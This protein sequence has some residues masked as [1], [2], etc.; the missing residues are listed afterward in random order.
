GTPELSVQVS[1]VSGGYDATSDELRFS[2]NYRATRQGEVCL[3]AIP[4]AE[5]P[6]VV[7]QEPARSAYVAGITLDF[8]FGVEHE[9]GVEGFFLEIRDLVADL[10]IETESLRTAATTETPAISGEIE[11][12]AVTL[13]A[14]VRVVFD[15]AIV[16]D[17]RISL[18]ELKSITSEN[19]EDL[20]QILP[21]G[22]LFAEFP[23][24]TNQEVYSEER[25]DPILIIDIR[26]EDIFGGG[27]PEVFVRTD[28]TTLKDP[29]L[30]LIKGLSETGEKAAGLEVLNAPLAVLDTSVAEL[31]STQLDMENALDF[32]TPALEYFTLLEVFN[33]DISQNSGDVGSLLGIPDFDI[34]D[35]THRLKLQNL[36]E[37]EYNL[38]LNPD[39]DLSL[40]LPEL[41]SLFNPDFE[42]PEYL[43]KFQ[44][45]LG[46]PYVPT[47]D[48]VRSDMKSY[49][50]AFPSL[51]GLLDYIRIT[52]RK[53]LFNG[54]S[55]QLASEPFLFEGAGE[56]SAAVQVNEAVDGLGLNGEELPD[57]PFGA[58]G[59]RFDFDTRAD[60][61]FHG[62][63]PPGEVDS[64]T[65]QTAPILKPDIHEIVFV[66]PRV[67]DYQTLIHPLT[68]Q[69]DLPSIET[70]ILDPEIDGVAQ[71]SEVLASFTDIDALHIIAHGSPGSLELGT[72]RLDST[73]LNQY[74]AR[75]EIWGDSLITDGDILLYGC[76]IAKGEKG[77]E[78]VERLS[79]LTGADVAA[80]INSTGGTALGGDWELEYSTGAI[81]VQALFTAPDLSSYSS[82]LNGSKTFEEVATHL[83]DKTFN[84]ATIVTHGFQL[85]NDGGNSLYPLADAIRTRIDSANDDNSV[86][87]L[88]YDVLEDGQTGVFNEDNSTL[89][90][91]TSN[92]GDLVLLFDWA[93]ESNEYS[94]GWGSAAGEALFTMVAGLGIVDPALGEAN[95]T[96][97]HFVAHSFGTAVTS[98]AIERLARF[99]VPVDQVTYLDPH[100]FDQGVIP[101][102]EA[103]EMFKLGL[104]AGYG[105][106]VW[107]NVAFADV[108]YQTEFPP[109]GR[110]IPGAFNT[111]VNDEVSGLSA[112]SEVWSE[113][114]LDTVTDTESTTGYAFSSIA[115]AQAGSSAVAR[116]DGNF[117]GPEQ[118]HEHSDID[119]DKI[120]PTEARL[121]TAAMSDQL[122]QNDID[123]G[124]W[125]PIWQPTTIANGTLKYGGDEHDGIPGGS[126]IIPGWSH[127]GGG[128]PAELVEMADGF[129]GI[130]LTNNETWRQHNR[131]YVASNIGEVGIDVNVL[132]FSGTTN[133][134]VRLDTVDGGLPA[135]YEQT[136]HLD[137][138]TVGIDGAFTEVLTIPDQHKNRVNT[139]RFEL[140]S[141]TADPV[142]AMVQVHEVRLSRQTTIISGPWEINGTQVL[143]YAG[144]VVFDATSQVTGKDDAIP[145]DLILD[146][147]GSVTILGQISGLRDL[148]VHATGDITLGSGVTVSTRRIAPGG[149]VAT[150]ASTGDSG[151]IFFSAHNVTIGAGTRLLAHVPDDDQVY[152]SGDI[153]ILAKKTGIKQLEDL[154][155]LHF[156]KKVAAIDIG[157][158]AQLRGGNLIIRSEAADKSFTTLLGTSE[159]FN[160][161]LIDPLIDSISGLLD[162]PFKVLFKE[163]DARVTVHENVVLTGTAGVTIEADSIAD[164]SGGGAADTATSVRF[165]VKATSKLFSIGYVDAVSSAVVDIKTGVTITAGEAVAINADGTATALL[166]TETSRDLGDYP[167]DPLKISLSLAITRTDI[168][169]QTLVADGVTITAGKTANITAEGL[170]DSEAEAEAG[171]Y[172]DGR[173]GLAFGLSF[174]DADI[175]SV[176]N[177]NVTAWMGP[178]SVVKLEFDPTVTDSNAIGFV[179]TTENTIKVGSHALATG[180][181]VEYSNRRGTSIGPVV[182][183][184]TDGDVFFVITTADPTK[185]K[186]AETRDKAIAGNAISLASG[187]AVNSKNF[188]PASAVDSEKDTITLANP[189]FTGSGT[190]FSLLGSTFELGQ[191]V[192]YNANGE[193]PIDGLVDGQVYYVITGTNQFSLQGDLRFVDKQVLQLAETENES[194]AGVAIDLDAT[195]ATG[196][197]TL[198]AMHVLD[199][200]LATGIGVLATLDTTAKGLAGSGISDEAQ[201]TEVELYN[202]QPDSLFQKLTDKFSSNS[203][204]PDSGA[205]AGPDLQVA[206]AV[207]FVKVNQTVTADV[208]ADAVLKSN[209]DLEVKA[210]ISEA[211][212]INAESSIETVEGDEAANVSISAAV[213]IG[214]ID[215]TAQATVGSGADLDALRATRVISDVSY[216]YIT[217]PDEFVPAN[218]GE[219]SDLLKSEGLDAVNDYGDGTLGLKSK[220]FN[221][222]A[223]SSGSA[224]GTAI[225]GSINFL[226][227]D[228][229]SE[230]IVQS[231]VQ[232]NQDLDW[233]DN[234]QNPHPNNTDQQVV[235]IEA[236]NYMQMLNVTGVFDF[237]LPGGTLDPL[238]V[239]YDPKLDIS[240]VA[241]GGGK[242]G[243]GGAI[244]ISL[245]DNTTTALVES[246]VALYSGSSGGFNMKAEEAI[247]SFNFSQAGAKAGKY[248]IAGTVAYVEQ[249]SMTRAQLA[250]GAII[251]GGADPDETDVAGSPVTIYAGSLE[252]NINWAG[253]VAK[254]QNL[255]FGITVAI[256]DIDRETSAI[257]GSIDPAIDA[258]NG[259]APGINT[260]INATGALKVDA[261]V[262][263]DLWSFTVAAAIAGGGDP[264]SSSTTG[265]SPVGGEDGKKPK[266]GIG[267]S[268]NVSINTVEDD[269][270]A[271]IHDAG[272]IQSPSVQLFALNETELYAYGAAASAVL[273]SEGS[274]SS[275][276][277][278]IAGSFSKNVLTG[279]TRAFIKGEKTDPSTGETTRLVLMSGDE[280]TL[281]AARKGKISAIAAGI[282]VAVERSGNSLLV[283]GS[284]S[285]NE[286]DNAT[287][288]YISGVDDDPDPDN[289]NAAMGT[290]DVSIQSQDTSSIFALAGSLSIGLGG[291]NLGVGFSL[292]INTIDN[293]TA[294]CLDNS[295]LAHAQDLTLSAANSADIRAITAS[296]SLAVG[297]NNQIALSGSVSIN[298]IEGGA[299]ACISDAEVTAG[300]NVVVRARDASSIQ[301]DGGGVSIGVKAGGKDSGGSGALGIS[302]AFNEVTNTTKAFVDDSTVSA[303]GNVDITAQAKGA[304][305]KQ[306]DFNKTAVIGNT[307]IIPD[308]EFETGERVVY[309]NPDTAGQEIS[310]LSYG[311]AYF[312]VRIDDN[313]IRLAKTAV[314]AVANTP[315]VIMLDASS[316]GDSHRLES[317]KATIKALALAGGLSAGVSQGSGSGTGISGTGAGAENTVHNTVEAYIHAPGRTVEA[318]GNLSVAA[319]D[320]AVISCDTIGAS[321]SVGVAAGKKGTAFSIGLSLAS[322]EIRNSVQAHIDD[323]TVTTMGSG[324]IRIMTDSSADIIATAVAASIA[325][326]FGDKGYA[327]SGGGAL[328]KNVILTRAKAYVLGSVLQSGGDI[329]IDAKSDS[330]IDAT[331]VAASLSAAGG[332]QTGGGASIGVSLARNVI[333]WETSAPGPTTFHTNVAF[334]QGTTLTAGNTVAVDQGAYS[335]DVYQYL[336]SNRI[337][338][339][340]DFDTTQSGVTLSAGHIVRIADGFDGPG[341][342]VGSFYRYTGSTLS[343]VNLAALD[344]DAD[345]IWKEIA[346][347]DL[348]TEDFS[349]PRLW[350]QVNLTPSAAQVQAFAQD[351]SMTATGDVTL[352]ANAEQGIDAVVIAGS[353]AVAGGGKTGVGVS[354]AGVYT[355]NKIGTHVKAYIDGDGA[356]AI[357]AGNI[358]LT[359]HDASAIEA[360][361]V[362]ASIAASFAGKTGVA[363]SIGVAIAMNEVSNEVDAYISDADMVTAT[364]DITVEARTLPADP[365]TADYTTASG[366]QLLE[367]GDTV[368][369]ADDYA[370]GGEAGRMYAYRGFV[371]DYNMS[372]ADFLWTD[373]WV[374]VVEG[375]TVR[376]DFT[377]GFFQIY[378]YVGEDNDGE[379]VLLHLPGQDYSDDDYWEPAE[380]E[381][382]EG[383][384]VQ[385]G[386]FVF[387]Y[388]GDDDDL[389]LCT[390]A[391]GGA[392]WQLIAPDLR[393]LG[394]ADYSDTK[395]WEL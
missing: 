115:R 49:F 237:Q 27:L 373:G 47:M 137:S 315:N 59:D 375:D 2:L 288:S 359:A 163:S 54:F 267:I 5:G 218:L 360:T 316:A 108:Y 198:T 215:N 33:F 272:R 234:T 221:T 376:V 167:N 286:V 349:D 58:S 31:L 244:F 142:N 121:N 254:G 188:I 96:L 190:D 222:W 70:L 149:D 386:N 390:Q 89:P 241:S 238:S 95:S 169:S 104:P 280:L 377:G 162:L 301:S 199:S 82:L 46:L 122:T 83:I 220:L 250:S 86:W 353:V 209:E 309:R 308:H 106:T 21:S 219:L 271:Y 365:D 302:L 362:A 68:T 30:N 145:D 351:S 51:K 282:A 11:E 99:E 127:H 387:R 332:S 233:R 372:L 60:Q 117:F 356:G 6:E 195:D 94:A 141:E 335:G 331:I 347:I 201:E 120:S 257:I 369:L 322:N 73:T 53:S 284:V 38:F 81:E 235:S 107:E 74:A 143:E 230:A 249:D 133:L 37:N 223:R 324:F 116:P 260:N 262:I 131:F 366:T 278:S 97:L 389:N 291:G 34:N 310:G 383:N 10:V 41:W 210:E 205:T 350:K 50:G 290:Y 67:P 295:N 292:G 214:L 352:G 71:I 259:T 287:A 328:A 226:D 268:A 342:N 202:F 245:L 32:Y 304:T 138:A 203:D 150:A 35:A 300:G 134:V 270:N 289:P 39:W 109:D 314:E 339:T 186:L 367:I 321:V 75:L 251:T 102:D 84:T 146:V 357:S 179:D 329:V 279:N 311:V 78:Y 101:V 184:L 197:H 213:I 265:E 12:G 180:D 164:A 384:T 124:K 139:I 105:A 269:V 125:R 261:K 189:A 20:I 298:T 144:N 175:K 26:S 92:S 103:Q 246:G 176:V 392:L 126:N 151:N 56:P 174:S 118:D 312:V 336:G 206:G 388:M 4:E 62:L 297:D 177:G 305:D 371:A 242:G 326:G 16:E 66:D 303:A 153:T 154:G 229:V 123:V 110:P 225:A 231:G 247:M 340:A 79:E 43:P 88:D 299:N 42:I 158:G 273:P 136:F 57:Q 93:P 147:D 7:F 394:I 61:V 132:V 276:S 119:L 181:K 354:G 337:Q 187:A 100:D 363:V 114:Y 69:P 283:A 224:G 194:R 296:G 344:Y 348:Q 36:L 112:H 240:P 385:V 14:E 193:N 361:A 320:N 346:S 178:G 172:T 171:L 165:P 24:K 381:I 166:K 228:N 64:F 130:E 152:T 76:N 111:L 266:Y 333:G 91:E 15:E 358:I 239:N 52:G 232:I 55:N 29:I 256:N 140:V 211:L 258:T 25:S 44:A 192:R 80:S 173:A 306:H 135:T 236:T 263:G 379:G 200:G 227:I 341:G 9:A 208:G 148:I 307:I 98:E 355:Q 90:D 19:V 207:G 343:N 327:L 391:Y 243:V 185:I 161:F 275:N 374:T 17:G 28:I 129:L 45:L 281:S 364:G 370:N 196:N 156:N 87:F 23:L 380:L 274:G 294:A 368:R 325:A 318:G 264:P 277:A 182:G 18:A 248:A 113:F 393:N 8:T 63:D 65:P 40:Y 216:P 170:E 253:A 13:E 157:A 183:G 160:E 317:D 323:S 204:K 255:G 155:P 191:A 77:V 168:T 72:V 382:H 217:R 334:P 330:D 212:Q 85:S 319:T 293:H 3:F 252:T 128:G 378:R 48:D 345:D 159:L 313:T 338:P 1:D 395:L 285:L 22:I